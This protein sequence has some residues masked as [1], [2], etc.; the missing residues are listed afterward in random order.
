MQMSTDKECWLLKFM[1]ASGSEQ[2]GAYFA[3]LCQMNHSLAGLADDK[4]IIIIIPLL[5]LLLL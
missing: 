2:K 4:I 3:H 1:A 5:L